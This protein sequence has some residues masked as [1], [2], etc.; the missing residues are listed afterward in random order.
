MGTD[1][2]KGGYSKG[3]AKSTA[4]DTNRPSGHAKWG[5][6]NLINECITRIVVSLP[7]NVYEKC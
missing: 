2:W 3:S 1:R 5:V 6:L 4:A 7:V